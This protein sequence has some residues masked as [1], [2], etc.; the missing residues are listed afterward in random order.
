MKWIVL[1]AGGGLGA[2]FRYLL[3]AWVDQRMATV[4]PWGTL[5]VNFVGSLVIGLIAHQIQQRDL[6]SSTL[7]LFLV[8][9]YRE[10]RA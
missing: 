10:K 9:M 8:S 5:T 6:V 7:Q 2:S 1:F 4:F 3:S